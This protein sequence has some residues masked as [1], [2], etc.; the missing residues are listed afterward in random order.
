[1]T[2]RSLRIPTVIV[3]LAVLTLAAI[4]RHEWF[5]QDYPCLADVIGWFLSVIVVVAASVM[6]ALCFCRTWRKP[7]STSGDAA[8]YQADY[9]AIPEPYPPAYQPNSVSG[10]RYAC[11]L[12][13]MRLA[14]RLPGVPPEQ[15]YIVAQDY[16]V[17]YTVNGRE[18]TITVPS[19]TLTDLA[20]VP[21][22]FRRYVGRVGP[23]LE[24]AIVHDF[25]Y[26]AW[27]FRRGSPSPQR[28]HEMRRFADDLMLAAM[29]EAGMGC[30]ANLIYRAIRCGGRGVF[31][32]RNP[33][34]LVLDLRALPKQVGGP[35]AGA[36][37]IEAGT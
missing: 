19:G 2:A 31:F 23:H 32:D 1:M 24:A 27:Q 9:D 29:Q 26:V 30:K 36:L 20:S 5:G 15:Q 22:L 25:L 7:P 12:H 4:W 6:L 33:E 34:P 14:E 11:P 8:E 21:W 35:P 37:P 17:C 28:M 16:T 13:L 10:F 3:V 18:E